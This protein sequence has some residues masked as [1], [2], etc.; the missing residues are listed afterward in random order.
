MVVVGGGGTV[1]GRSERWWK[2]QGRNRLAPGTL[3][4]GYM[5]GPVGAVAP[6]ACGL[7]G[8]CCYYYYD[9]CC[10]CW[11]TLFYMAEVCAAM[12]TLGSSGVEA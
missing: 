5:G 6:D 8:R 9:F 2:L 4:F 3:V 7:S 11:K 1:G 10:R 12:A